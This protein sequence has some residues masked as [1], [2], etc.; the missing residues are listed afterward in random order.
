MLLEAGLHNYELSSIPALMHSID[1][2]ISSPSVCE[3]A[4]GVCTAVAHH[5]CRGQP[6]VWVLQYLLVQHLLQMEL[7]WVCTPP[8]FASFASYLGRAAPCVQAT[9]PHSFVLGSPSGKY[10]NALLYLLCLWVK[11]PQVQV[12]AQ[13]C[14]TIFLLSLEK[15]ALHV[16][17]A[18][19]SQVHTFSSEPPCVCTVQWVHTAAPC[20]TCSGRGIAGEIYKS[21]AD[22]PENLTR[23]LTL[24]YK[25][26]R[27]VNNGT[28][29]SSGPI[30]SPLLLRSS[31]LPQPSLCSLSVLA[32]VQKL[33]TWALS[34]LLPGTAL[35][36]GIHFMWFFKN[37]FY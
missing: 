4:P 32:V 12:H 31:H 21:T 29:L 25:C 37:I 15:L 24:L 11:Q 35:N 6:C 14:S 16:G 19:F 23:T 2:V 26:R 7:P 36:I 8:H 18:A 17:A 13:Q 20:H 9:V 3:V 27:E 22:Q 33:F 28:H 10:R 1:F 30:E 34:C 5:L